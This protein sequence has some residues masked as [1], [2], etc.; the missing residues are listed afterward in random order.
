MKVILDAHVATCEHFNSHKETLK[1]RNHQLSHELEAHKSHIRSL[2]QRVSALFQ[3]DLSID[4][5]VK[6]QLL[7]FLLLRNS[8]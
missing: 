2:R 5:S 6:V 3:Q 8:F 1:E 4:E 7:F